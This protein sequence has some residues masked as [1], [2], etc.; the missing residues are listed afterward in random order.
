MPLP[1]SR[2]LLKLVEDSRCDVIASYVVD[3][4]Q[5]QGMQC[6]VDKQHVIVSADPSKLKSQVSAGI[7]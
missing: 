7:L 2:Y 5:A 3:L 6:L 4:L 1:K